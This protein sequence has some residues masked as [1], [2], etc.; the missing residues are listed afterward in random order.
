MGQM[1]PYAEPTR[2]QQLEA[3]KGQAEYFETALNDIRKRL[4]E[5]EVVKTDK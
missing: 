1:P 2:Q 5:M 3:L 4:Q